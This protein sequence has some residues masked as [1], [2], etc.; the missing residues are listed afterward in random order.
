MLLIAG[1]TRPGEPPIT[2][3][4]P[5]DMPVMFAYG[6]LAH[7]SAEYQQM[8]HPRT[9][10]TIKRMM[11]DGNGEWAIVHVHSIGGD[12]AYR[13]QDPRMIVQTMLKQGLDVEWGEQ[14]VVHGLRAVSWRRASMADPPASCLAMVR[15]LR[16][17]VEG[18]IGRGVQ[19]FAAGLYCRAGAG[20]IP[21]DEIPRI[22]S[23]LQIRT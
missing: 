22:A 12:Y 7:E 1:C 11:V 15:S 6:S 14:G 3:I 13:T 10:A 23:A 8:V 9:V 20:S 2:E 18:G 19:E 5:E 4:Y 17:H 21:S 16:E